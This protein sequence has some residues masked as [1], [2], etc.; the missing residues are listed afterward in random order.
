M[1]V[2]AYLHCQRHNRVRTR[3]RIPN[4]VPALYYEEHVHIVQTQIRIPVPYFCTGQESQCESV[5]E[6]V[7]GNVN[8]P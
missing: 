2:M 7:F 6:S 5:P 1:S 3:I 4:P 8:E